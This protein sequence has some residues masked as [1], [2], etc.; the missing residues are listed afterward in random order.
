V[1]FRRRPSSVRSVLPSRPSLCRS[2]GSAAGCGR[3]SG[4]A[5]QA[6]DF[7]AGKIVIEAQDV[8]D[9][10]AAPAIDRLVVIADAADVLSGA[11]DWAAVIPDARGSLT[12]RSRGERLP[13]SGMVE[14][15]DRN[16]R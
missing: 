4:S 1:T 9:L 13:S 5:L 12:R 8:V 6:D 11:F 10:G 2:D 14:G 15:P 7:G 16:L 3:W